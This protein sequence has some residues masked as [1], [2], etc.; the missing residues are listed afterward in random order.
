MK[1]LC[2]KEKT[3][4]GTGGAIIKSKKKLENFFFLINGDTYFNFN[5]LFLKKNF[6]IK[7]FDLIISTKKQLNKRYGELKIRNNIVYKFTKPKKIKKTFINLGVYICKKKIFNN[8]YKNKFLSLENDILPKLAKEKKI[9]A[10]N[11]DN[12][13]FI[14]IG[15]KRDLIIAKQKLPKIHKLYSTCK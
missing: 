5:L 2:I 12:S 6:L 4:L 11:F 1:I 7:N 10:L 14:D 9:Q 3:P 8:F 13:F 15:I